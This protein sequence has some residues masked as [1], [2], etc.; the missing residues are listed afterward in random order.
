LLDARDWELRIDLPPGWLPIYLFLGLVFLQASPL[1]GALVGL[2]SPWT[3][4]LHQT[5]VRR[6]SSHLVPS[7]SRRTRRCGG[8]KLGAV[9]AFFLY[10]NTYG[11]APVLRAI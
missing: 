6:A 9:A 7:P 5:G 3:L 4:G 11:P 8:P 2:V 10:Y 1:P